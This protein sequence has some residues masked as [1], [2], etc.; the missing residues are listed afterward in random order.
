MLPAKDT[1]EEL[2]Y[3]ETGMSTKQNLVVTIVMTTCCYALAVAIPG[4]GDVITILGCTTNPMIGFILPITFYLKIIDDA[5][6]HKKI[7]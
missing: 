6:L 4:I 5:P 1:Y 2:A 7:I 3:P